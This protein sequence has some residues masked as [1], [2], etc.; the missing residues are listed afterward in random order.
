MTIRNY[1]RSN[2]KLVKNNNRIKMEKKYQLKKIFNKMDKKLT[3]KKTF[4]EM[5]NQHKNKK[6][7]KLKKII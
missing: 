7:K 2:K 5:T 6:W 1:N 4:K 3:M